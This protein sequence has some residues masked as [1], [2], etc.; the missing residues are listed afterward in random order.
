MEIPLGKGILHPIIVFCKH[1]KQREDPRIW[2]G[3][4]KAHFLQPE[5]HALDMLRGIRPFILELDNGD[6]YL[7]K[8][9]KGYDAVARNNLLSFKF[10][11]LN[12]QDITAPNMF[13]TVL[14]DSFER[15]LEYEITGV[16]KKGLPTHMPTLLQLLLTKLQRSRKIEFEFNRRFFNQFYPRMKQS[17]A[18]LTLLISKTE[19]TA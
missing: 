8:V 14:E 13:K 19:G 4:I 17:Y 7:G 2:A 10:E 16:Q 6:Q 18:K 3:I 15:N 11:S 12:L 1:T 5:T 9:A